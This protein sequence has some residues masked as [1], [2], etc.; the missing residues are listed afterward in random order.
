MKGGDY[1]PK[2]NINFGNSN[3]NIQ[4]Q[5]PRN[6]QLLN[7]LGFEED[8]LEMF[9]ETFNIS[10]NELIEKYME[11]ANSAPYNLNWNN[12]EDAVNSNYDIDVQK[13]NGTSY[14]KHDIVNDVMSYFSENQQG[15]KRLKNKKHSKSKKRKQ[16]KKRKS[17][18]NKSKKNKRRKQT[19]KRRGGSDGTENYSQMNSPQKKSVTLNTELNQTLEYPITKLEKAQKMF[20][21]DKEIKP[22]GKPPVFPCRIVNTIFKRNSDYKEY[23]DLIKAQN[24]STGFK[25]VDKHYYDVN[26]QLLLKG[27]KPITRRR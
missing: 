7:S 24:A 11:I 19:K 1:I 4:N 27:E 12:V 17:S 23:M 9:F 26:S 6:N 2:D 3:S 5:M 10:E 16:T 15:G 13:P 18:K 25:P 22:C 14:T 21:V 20:E 8:E